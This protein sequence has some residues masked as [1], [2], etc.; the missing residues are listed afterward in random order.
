[1]TTPTLFGIAVWHCKLKFMHRKEGMQTAAMLVVVRFGGFLAAHIT[2]LLDQ[3]G[4]CGCWVFRVV[5]PRPSSNHNRRRGT[6]HSGTFTPPAGPEACRKTD[7][8]E[9]RASCNAQGQPEKLLLVRQRA[10]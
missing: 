3:P 10:H 4:H 8:L 5:L 7:A 2:D 6:V 9:A 1:M